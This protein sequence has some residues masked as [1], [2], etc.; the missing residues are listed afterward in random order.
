MVA[1]STIT[2]MVLA[3]MPVG[4][5]DKRLVL[6]T[7]EKGKISAFARGARKPN[8]ALLACS[9]PFCFGEFSIYAGRNSYN[10][11]S[12]NI[13]NYFTEARNDLESISYGCYF[14]ELV[15]HVT[16]ENN[17]EVEVLKL[18]YQTMRAL[19]KQSIPNKLI[20]Y[21]F[22]LKIMSV[23][24]YTP[25]VFECVSCGCKENVYLFSIAKGGLVCNQC[26]K[27]DSDLISLNGSTIYTMQFIILTPIEKLYTFNV[28]EQVLRELKKVME[29]YLRIM[30]DRKFKSLDVLEMF[31][32]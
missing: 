11:V 10:I 3:A 26:K 9:Q 32:K 14:A 18:L 7:K 24:G 12:A 17:D 4:D 6:L 22:E 31:L 16:R 20:R 21:I 13:T 8:S 25:Q 5:Y 15:E 27:G 30:I 28:N 1:Q 19:T 2:G 23:N 29:R